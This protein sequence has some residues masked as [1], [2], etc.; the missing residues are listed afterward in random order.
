MPPVP[1][2]GAAA[3]DFPPILGTAPEPVAGMVK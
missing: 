1:A 3:I 2:V